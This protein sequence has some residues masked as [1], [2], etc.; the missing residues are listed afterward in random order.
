MS[1][2][3]KTLIAKLNPTC[4]EAAEQAA[5]RCLARGH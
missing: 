4:R 1:T 5:S 2:P 3:L